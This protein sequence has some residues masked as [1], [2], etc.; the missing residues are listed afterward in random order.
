MTSRKMKGN[1]CLC[2]SSGRR[3][4]TFWPN[5]CL[6]TWLCVAQVDQ[7]K[8]S[9]SEI[10]KSDLLTEISDQGRNCRDSPDHLNLGPVGKAHLA[11][12][13]GTRMRHNVDP[14]WLA[15]S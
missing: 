7:P 4:S 3:I 12:I 15:L 8:T 1:G 6:Q 10:G 11:V 13:G 2:F 9:S 14:S 5:A